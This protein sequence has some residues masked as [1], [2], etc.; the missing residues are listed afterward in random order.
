[1]RFILSLSLSLSLS[2]PTLSSMS[3]AGHIPLTVTRVAA[4]EVLAS[5]LDMGDLEAERSGRGDGGGGF[6]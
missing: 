6:L 4:V 1:M 2:F 3:G 5:F